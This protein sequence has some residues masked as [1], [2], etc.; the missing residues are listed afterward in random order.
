M[1]LEAEASQAGFS[2]LAAAARFSIQRETLFR[3]LRLERRNNAL[4]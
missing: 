2:S 4:Q 3:R 1:S